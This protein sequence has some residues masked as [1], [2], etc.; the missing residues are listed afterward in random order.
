[1]NVNGCHTIFFVAS[2]CSIGI[3]YVPDRSSQDFDDETFYEYTTHTQ[4][5]RQIAVLTSEKKNSGNERIKHYGGE[6]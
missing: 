6:P 1:M 5:Y 2:F 3:R 4:T